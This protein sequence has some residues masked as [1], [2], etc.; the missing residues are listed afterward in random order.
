MSYSTKFPSDKLLTKIE[1]YRTR[2][3]AAVK[4]CCPEDVATS[5]RAGLTIEATFDDGGVMKLTWCLNRFENVYKP[6]DLADDNYGEWVTRQRSVGEMMR[7]VHEMQQEFL[8]IMQALKK[9]GTLTD[10]LWQTAETQRVRLHQKSNKFKDLLD[11][12]AA[13]LTPAEALRFEAA[14]ED[15]FVATEDGEIV[16]TVLGNACMRA[17]AASG[18]AATLSWWRKHKHLTQ[19]VR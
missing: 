14:E 9:D 1:E 4:T 6:V 5:G 2:A 12:T 16:A 19:D 18:K 11:K 7:R 3:L 15:G 10:S 13:T 8:A 17:A